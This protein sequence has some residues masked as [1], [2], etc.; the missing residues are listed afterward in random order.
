M[1]DLTMDGKDVSSD[2]L[3][4][5][6]ELVRI[7]SFSGQEEP[8]ARAIAQKMEMLGYDSV[9]IDR[10]GNVV[11]KIGQGGKQVLLESHTDTVQVHDE[12]LWETAPFSGEVIDGYLWG[13]GS[14]DM[15][16]GI[17]ASVYAGA[18]AKSKGYLNDTSLIVSC[19]VFEEDCD[20]EGLKF[21]LKEA[22]LKPDFAVICEPS[23]NTI[24]GGHK[25]KAQIIIKTQGVSAHGSAPEKGVNAIYEMAEIIERVK[26]MN[27]ELMKKNGRRGTLVLARI[28]STGVSLN[29]VP[30]ECEIYLDRRM[31][32][33]ETEESVALEMERIIA[34]KHATWEIDTVHRTT[35]TGEAITYR[36]LH[37]AW[38]IE[39]AHPLSKACM[40]AYEQVF[41]REHGDFGYWDFSTNAVALIPLGIPTIGFGPGE[42][43]LAHMRDEKCAVQQIV[44]AC[45]F[46]IKVIEEI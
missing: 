24:V 23:N 1:S 5:T 15:K 46:Y 40:R 28:S 22:G 11:G 26:K 43:K 36:P 32:M 7:K 37:P 39:R 14:V 42:A 16:S 8:A 2:V 27:L 9:D 21:V 35:W 41:G 25:G 19:S 13:R 31:V 20:G 29:A 10:M 4:F 30:S 38:E 18:I 6:Q 33:G 17:A 34:G 3:N 44:E 45:A 12:P